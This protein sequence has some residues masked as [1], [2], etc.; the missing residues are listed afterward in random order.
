MTQ[1]LIDDDHKNNVYPAERLNHLY[2]L[3]VFFPLWHSQN[4]SIWIGSA[5]YALPA[6]NL[7]SNPQPMRVIGSLIVTACG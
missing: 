3:G 6:D 7:D 1:G 4:N 2:V 5:S